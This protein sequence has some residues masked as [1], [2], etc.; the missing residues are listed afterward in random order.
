MD[1]ELSI[2]AKITVK[3][4]QV[5]SLYLNIDGTTVPGEVRLLIPVIINDKS[6]EEEA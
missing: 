6:M 3:M 1:A 4:R 5:A 2:D